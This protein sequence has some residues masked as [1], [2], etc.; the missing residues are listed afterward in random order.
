MAQSD[1]PPVTVYESADL[2]IER[3]TDGVYVHVSYLQ[4]DGF[5]RVACNGMVY[6]QGGEAVVVDTP[7]DQPAAEALLTWIDTALQVRTTAVVATHFHADCTGGLS[8]FH[9]RG[10]P[11]FAHL[12]TI[13]LARQ[14]GEPVPQHGFDA[15]L[16]LR[17]GEGT[18][19]N[20]YFGPGHT[21]DNVVS[22]VPAADV[23]FGGCLVKA[24]G[25]G[26][27]NLDDA[28]VHAWSATVA[29]VRDAYPGVRWVIPGHGAAGDSRLLDYTVELFE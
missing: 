28:D 25:A 11:S 16:V 23:L 8:A 1:T 22:Y 10:I 13:S 3:V 24:L 29:A 18:V 9:A 14:A 15:W 26:K 6:R 27:G 4:V 12:H 21:H 20:R 2:R 5:G 19:E 7:A 17:V